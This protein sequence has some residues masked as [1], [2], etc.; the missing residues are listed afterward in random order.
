MLVEAVVYKD[1][2]LEPHINKMDFLEKYEIKNDYHLKQRIGKDLP[3]SIQME[4]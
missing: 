4:K 3:V 1:T 2:H